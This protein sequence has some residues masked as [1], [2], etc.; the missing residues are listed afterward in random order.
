[1]MERDMKREHS[2]SLVR[3]IAEERERFLSAWQQGARTPELNQIRENIRQL[4]D[5]LWDT[6]LGTA[7]SPKGHETSETS[8]RVLY[9]RPA[10]RNHR[11]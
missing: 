4:N 5:R 1:M 2:E 11:P 6:T 3:Q 8:E 10:P 9:D 7:N